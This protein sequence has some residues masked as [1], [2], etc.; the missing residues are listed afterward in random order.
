MIGRSGRGTFKDPYGCGE[1]VDSSGCPKS[2]RNDGRRGDEIVG[3]SVVQITL[4]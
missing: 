3:E 4:W 2:R 1:I